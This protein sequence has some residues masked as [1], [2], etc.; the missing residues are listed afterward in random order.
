ML[1]W[2][3]SRCEEITN[4]CG[5]R[6]VDVRRLKIVVVDGGRVADVWELQI[7]VVVA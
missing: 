3:R 6:V 2:S 7:V 5:G 1:W 4:C